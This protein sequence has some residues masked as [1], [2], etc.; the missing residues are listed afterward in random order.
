MTTH[1]QMIRPVT[2][3]ESVTAPD[4]ADFNAVV[5]ARNVV[6]AEIAGN[7]DED[8]PPAQL[9]VRFHEDKTSECRVWGTLVDGEIVGRVF[10]DRP[11]E[12]DAKHVY[13]ETLI[14]RAYWNRGLGSVAHEVLAA[15]AREHGRTVMQTWAE[16]PAD[17]SRPHLTPPTG[18]GSIPRDHTAQFLLNRGYVLEQVERKSV[19]DLANSRDHIDA[20]HQQYVVPDDYRV[21]SWLGATPPEHVEAYARLKERMSV[22]APSAGMDASEETWDADRVAQ[23]D[24]IGLANDTTRLTTV[25]RHVS[26]GALVAYN[27]LSIGTDLTAATEQADTL[28]VAA[29][30]GKKLGMIVKLAGL[31]GWRAVAPLSPRLLTWNAEENRPMLDVN[32]AIG[33]VP[34]AYIGAWRL[35]LT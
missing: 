12:D 20:L 1:T 10:V 19:L 24:A 3:P 34:D 31:I 27:E 21:E 4:A 16:H 22:D 14:P 35:E 18:F 2:V 25:V 7:H 13:V 33:F 15:Y 8:A 5:A 17:A 26:T 32:E 11:L 6:Y 23:S 9:L 30:R 28:V 29:H